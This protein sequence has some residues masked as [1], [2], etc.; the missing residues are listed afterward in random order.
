[1][2]PE[3]SPRVW[4]IARVCHEANRAYCATIGDHS[5]KPWLE[6]PDWQRDSAVKGVQ[7]HLSGE[8]TPEE[9]HESWLA[10][11]IATGWKYGAVKDEEKKEHPCCVPYAEL[12]EAQKKKD[13]LFTAVVAALR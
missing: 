5:Q 3:F 9:S 8:R 11:K 10:V 13:A 12:P 7:F 4:D 2:E 6:C 1:M